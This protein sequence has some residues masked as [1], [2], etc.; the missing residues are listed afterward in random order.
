MTTRQRQA[1]ERHERHEHARTCTG[2]KLLGFMTTVGGQ[3]LRIL[4]GVTCNSCP[5]G[6][7]IAKQGAVALEQA[8]ERAARRRGPTWITKA[9]FER[10]HFQAAGVPLWGGI[11]VGP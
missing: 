8:I 9:E 1:A 11:R 7:F 4:D 3:K 6:E 2:I 10:Q 5:K